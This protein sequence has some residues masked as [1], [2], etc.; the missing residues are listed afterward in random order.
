LKSQRL[1]DGPLVLRFRR[2]M[3]LASGLQ[4]FESCI[5]PAAV[6]QVPPPHPAVSDLSD[7]ALVS[8]SI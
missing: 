5:S 8:G 2:P 3:D 7:R 1:A 4:V 6:L